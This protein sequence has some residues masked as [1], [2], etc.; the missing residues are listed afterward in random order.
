[1][2]RRRIKTHIMPIYVP[3]MYALFFLFKTQLNSIGL[4]L[5]HRKHS[6]TDWVECSTS[7]R[8]WCNAGE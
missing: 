6:T 2:L 1:M 8:V 3:N 7:R 5:P 4:S